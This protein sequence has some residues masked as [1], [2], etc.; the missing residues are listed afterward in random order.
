[1]IGSCALGNHERDSDFTVSP[2]LS[3]EGGDFQLA[4]GLA[5]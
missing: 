1:M 5:A 4:L 2:S 3:D